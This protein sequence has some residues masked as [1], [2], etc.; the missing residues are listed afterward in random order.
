MSQLIR[1]LI[2]IKLFRKVY[3]MDRISR[4]YRVICCQINNLC[5]NR[6]HQCNSNSNNCLVVLLRHNPNH[7]KYLNNFLNRLTNHSR[8]HPKFTNR[9]RHHHQVLVVDHPMHLQV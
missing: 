2:A 6:N 7:S 9:A 4:W 1:S 8:C 3:H 5:I